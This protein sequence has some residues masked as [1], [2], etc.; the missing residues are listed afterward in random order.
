MK[1]EQIN[2][3]TNCP[4]CNSKVTVSAEGDTHFYIPSP[5]IC[6][7]CSRVG[8][9]AEQIRILYHELPD[10]KLKKFLDHW[11]SPTGGDGITS[12]DIIAEMDSD[13]E[14]SG[15]AQG[16]IESNLNHWQNK[17]LIIKK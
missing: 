15:M 10:C 7:Q 12:P 13:M 8:N 3:Q 4:T 2:S 9:T 17:Y 6:P 16:E 14:D 1:P 5:A 11:F